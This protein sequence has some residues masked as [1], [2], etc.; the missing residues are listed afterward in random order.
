MQP[1]VQTAH[2]DLDKVILTWKTVLY[3]LFLI[4]AGIIV[5]VI[6][7]NSILIPNKL[8]GAGVSG[9]AI[10]IHYLFPSADVGITY[11]LLNIPLMFIGWF[12]ISKRFMLYT[13][14]GMA[15]FS[16]AAVI[17]KTPPVPLKDPILVAVFAGVVCGA[18]AGIVLRSLGSAG[19]VDILAT[20]ANKQFGLR[21]GLTSLFVNAVVIMIGAYFFGL[22]IALYSLIYVFTSSKAL[23][24]V[25]TG[26]NQRLST[27]VISDKYKEIAEE[28]FKKVNRGAT[29]LQAQ[30]AYSG[31]PKE[32][33][34]TI[35]TL[36]EL[37]KL[38]NVIFNIDPEAF[39]VVNSTL[40]VIGKRHGTR[41][42][43]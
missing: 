3:N 29:F 4:T 41:K 27:M 10:I 32:V 39:V 1:K 17:I 36:T 20:Y 13:I 7:M 38:K 14:F 2:F 6:G 22:Q 9:V 8:L 34:F 43:Y 33:I 26:F 16:L 40:E 11:F 35:T 19:G 25:L 18:G 37:P 15:F 5:F 23:D 28:I 21:P 31:D 24:A 30:G 12:S 42:V